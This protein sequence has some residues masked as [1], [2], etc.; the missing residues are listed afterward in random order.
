MAIDKIFDLSKFVPA[1]YL[2]NTTDDAVVI[3][4]R[5]EKSTMKLHRFVALD[6]EMAWLTGFFLAEG[7]KCD[8]AIGASN[9]EHEL[10]KR[11]CNIVE[12][13]ILIDKPVWSAFVRTKG[14]IEKR[15]EFWSEKLPHAKITAY[16]AELANSDN[17]EIRLNNRPLAY[18]FNALAKAV[19]EHAIK[20]ELLSKA[21]LKGYAIGDGSIIQ[22]RG[23]FYG[24]SIVTKS[25]EYKNILMN[26]IEKAYGKT[27]KSRI[28]KGSNEILLVGVDFAHKLIADGWFEESPRQWEKLVESFKRKE[29]T[30]SHIRYWKALSGANMS[31]LQLVEATKRSHW[32]VR[33]AMSK[34][35]NAGLVNIK[36]GRIAGTR[37][38]YHVFYSLAD[39]GE[40]LLKK[41]G[42]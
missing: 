16:R 21:F 28:S 19:A 15:S 29:Y 5:V 4:S 1:K 31:V 25:D 30:R 11:F 8:Y 26:A 36:R 14:D 24:V 17:I 3:G 23:Y 37:G 35:S 27:A 33:D 42:G 2:K 38:P 32:A 7:T 6:E 10:V 13:C 39:K 9:C 41:L 20:N 18:A 40:C 34:D 12:R 22:R